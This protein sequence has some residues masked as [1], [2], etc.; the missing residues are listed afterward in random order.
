MVRGHIENAVLAAGVQVAPK[1]RRKNSR[2]ED[3][4]RSGATNRRRV[5][6]LRGELAFR[7]QLFARVAT[8][9]MTD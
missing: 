9:A 4:G 1:M 8:R 6:G 5:V 3:V 2:C 7:A